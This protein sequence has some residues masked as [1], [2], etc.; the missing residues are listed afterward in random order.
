MSSTLARKTLSAWLLSSVG[1]ASLSLAL[2]HPVAA[3]TATENGTTVNLQPAPIQELGQTLADNGITVS[4][5]YNGEF[6]ANPSGGERQG[7]DFTGE[8]NLGADFDLDR[9]VGLQGGTI[10]TLFTARAGNNL[11]SKAINNSVS[12]Q[13]IFGGGQTYQL[14]IFTYEQKLFNDAVDFT[15]GRTDIFD[16]FVTSPFYCDFQSNAACGNPSYAGKAGGIESSYY[17]VAVWG[18]LV[19]FNVTPNIYLKTGLYQGAPNINPV[20]GHGFNWSFNHSDGAQGAAE[21]GYATSRPGAAQPDQYDAG[22][23]VSRTHF[24]APWF[25]AE[26]PEQF[27]QNFV[28][29][30]AQKMLYQPVAN[31]P[32]GLYA[33]AVGMVGTQGSKQQANYSV[34]AGAIY[35]GIF[36]SRPLDYVGLMVNE[37]HYNNRFL[38]FLHQERIAEGGTQNPNANLVMMELNYTAQVTRWL[39]FTPNIQYIV[40]PDGLGGLAYPTTNQHNALVLGLQFQVDVANLFGLAPTAAPPAV[41]GAVAPVAAPAPAPANTYLVFFDWDKYNLTPRA[42]EI[43]GNAATDSRSQSVTTINVSGYTDTSGLAVYNQKLSVRRAKAVAAQLI[44]DGVP[45]S[46]IEIHGYGE[47]HLLVPTGPGVR[48][49]QNRRVEIILH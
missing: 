4:S 43:I 36:P 49:P 9:L 20:A 27:G 30:Q 23:V 18:G 45:A 15:V 37:V 39:N 21:V 14:T 48:E 24:A 32:Q 3:Q 10:H 17:P 42:V 29:A 28:Y 33:F 12:V 8:L 11:A 6:A 5:R 19:Q 13:Q 34:E 2:A 47:T 41:P 26:S 44:S 31:A 25:N 7:A 46:E 40:N 22:I 38:N 1:M 16:S 35:E